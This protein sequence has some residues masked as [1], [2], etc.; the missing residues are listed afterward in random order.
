MLKVFKL[1]KR[2]LPNSLKLIIKLMINYYFDFILYVKNSLVFNQNTFEKKEAN[3]ILQYHGLE[4]GMLFNPMRP[5]FAKDRVCKIHEILKDPEVKNKVN[6]SQV[7]IG[8][9]VI[10]EYYEIHQEKGIDISDYYTKEQYLEYLKIISPVNRYF[11]SGKIDIN[12]DELYKSDLDF[13]DFAHSRKSIR[14]YND[15]YVSHDVIKKVVNLA[16]TAPSVCNR[17]SARVKLIE[18]KKLISNILMIQGGFNGYIEN[19]KQLLILTVDRQYFYTIG[20]RNQFYIDGGI[21][22]LNLLYALHYYKIA[23]CP[24]NWGKDISSEIE[25]DRIFK[26]PDS[27][28][29]ICIIPIGICQEKVSV[30]LSQRRDVDE[31]LEIFGEYTK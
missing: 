16:N 23:A 8:Y 22:L 3:L 19:V 1:I 4:K 13:Y 18:D 9:K 5:R 7:F 20:E 21:Y 14:H 29:I 28:K 15:K 12:I 10:I 30:T 24:A 26:I 25:L 17:Q 11:S 31:V 27:E 2:L 6:S